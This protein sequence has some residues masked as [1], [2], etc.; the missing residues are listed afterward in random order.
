VRFYS[1]RDRSCV[2]DFARAIF[3]GLAPDGGLYHP[4]S[5]PDLRE[6]ILQIPDDRPFEELAAELVHGMLPDVFDMPSALRVCRRAFPFAPK[7]RSLSDQMYLLELFHGPSCAFKDFGAS[8]LAATMEHLLAGEDRRAVILTATSGDT[9]SAVARAF[10]GRPGIDV[11]ILYPSGRVSPLQEQQLTTVGD[12]VTALEVSGSFDDCQRMAKQAFTN[13]ELAHRIHLTSANSINLGRLI[14]QTL[15]YV[16][17]FIRL[18]SRIV[19]DVVF[20]V[21]SGNFGNL[22]AGALAWKWGL[23]VSRF[24]A[25][26]NMNDI[27]PEY[28]RAGRF[29][30]RPSLQ[31]VANAMDV[32]DPS[33]FERMLEIFGPDHQDMRVMVSG[34]AV[35]DEDIIET[36]RRIYRSRHVFL[37]PHTAAGVCAAERY[38]AGEGAGD[39]TVI[40]LATAHPAKFPEIVLRATGA[41]AEL[42]ERLAEAMRREKRSVPIEPTD[43]ALSTFLLEHYDTGGAT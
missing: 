38:L 18:R 36:M 25:A 3:T 8:F 17:A 43:R 5:E 24:I 31:T 23:P 11:V 40:T 35:T 26:T 19:S 16:D 39:A 13:H 2:V 4:D 14:P 21:P 7:L 34:E 12:N 6:L 9:G 20:C 29:R 37:D 28:L 30:P 15:Y 42:P 22:T 27:V 33:N 32:G 10:H 41:V 1:T